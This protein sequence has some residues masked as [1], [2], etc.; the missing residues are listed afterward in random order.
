M[1][2]RVWLYLLP[3]IIVIIV[4]AI[5][6]MVVSYNYAALNLIAGME[7]TFEGFGMIYRAISDESFLDAL[8]RN[9]LFT[10]LA[11]IPEVP[12]GILIAKAIPKRGKLGALCMVLIAIPLVLPWASI[13]LTWRIMVR[14]GGSLWT[15]FRTLGAPYSLGNP[16]HAFGLA[17]LCDIWHWT[18]LVA[19][20]VSAGY[21]AMRTEPTEAAMID[22]ASRWAIFRHVELPALGFPILM[23][24]MLRLMDSL[25]VY[26]EP[27]MILG[28]GPYQ[29]L[30]FISTNISSSLDSMRFGYGAAQS[31]IYSFIA[32]MAFYIIST[33]I[34]KG[35]GMK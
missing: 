28:E 21:A 7:P 33:V 24:V 19:L 20:V 14:T 27:F 35:R 15:I 5:L 13:G 31:L 30:E 25:R 32:I 2:F 3:V 29:S 10:F 12:L 18:P 23:A 11:L 9:G 26:D 1:K 17:L 4:N 34:T 6:P 16:T 22:R 8:G